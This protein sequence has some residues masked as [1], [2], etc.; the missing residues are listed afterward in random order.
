M[1]VGVKNRHEIFLL[2]EAMKHRGH[3]RNGSHWSSP[4]RQQC[5]SLSKTLHSQPQHF[6]LYWFNISHRFKMWRTVM[7][8]TPAKENIEVKICSRSD[9]T[10]VL[11]FT[12]CNKWHNWTWIWIYRIYYWKAERE[13]HISSCLVFFALVN[14]TKGLQRFT[15]S[16]SGPNMV[17][18]EFKLRNLEP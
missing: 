5:E 3:A 8:S 6:I 9:F 13:K 16:R 10:N 4:R 14:T 1:Y 18:I 15:A 2:W 17:N 7:K 11:R 12:N